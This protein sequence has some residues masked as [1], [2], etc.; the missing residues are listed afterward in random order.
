MNHTLNVLKKRRV[1]PSSTPSQE[2]YLVFILMLA[3]IVSFIDRQVISLLVEPIKHDLGINDTQ[4]SL[5]MGLAF[6]IFYVAMGVPIARLSDYRNRKKII[7]VGILFWSLATAA[8]GFAKNFP[9]LFL[10]RIGVGVGEATLSPAAYSMIADAFPP[11]KLARAVAVYSM[12]AFLGAGIAGLVGGW[13][14][15]AI[16]AWDTQSWPLIGNLYPWQL[17]FI[18]VSLPGLLLVALIMATIR[19]PVRKGIMN[20]SQSGAVPFSDVLTFLCLNKVT[21]GSIFTA[22][23]FGGVAFYGFMSWIP[24][25]VRRTH[26]WEIGEAGMIFGGIFAVFGSGGVLVGGWICDK[27]TQGGHKDAAIKC[28]AV[29][30]A[31]ALPL[32]VAMPLMPTM[33]SVIPTLALMSFA[34]ASQQ[35]MSPVAIQLV[36]PNEM[37]AQVT[38]IFFVAATFPAIG[39]G[40]TSVALLTDYLF[41][42]DSMIRFS[43][44]I[45]GFFSMS[46]A[47]A[48]LGLGIKAYRAS[49]ERSLAWRGGDD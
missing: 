34:I 30:F 47:A 14:V 38:A 39:F 9:Q 44:A 2:W 45:V 49:I 48:S 21:F 35:A 12:G 26:G 31:V 1:P 37:R 19:E 11:N 27:L 41:R 7:S 25:F 4:V 15:Q 32:M 3:F 33:S 16:S 43:L 8:C 13:A 29:F 42:D 6:A 28:A 10:A 20:P 18:L 23:A 40:A 5:L 22:Y 24:E 46:I 17:T 36:T